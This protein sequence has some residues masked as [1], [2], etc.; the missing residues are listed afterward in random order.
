MA[1]DEA[2]LDSL[3]VTDHLEQLYT[4]YGMADDDFPDCIETAETITDENFLAICGFEY[5]SGFKV[6]R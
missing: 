6:S 1:R 3:A 5:G 2:G 4:L